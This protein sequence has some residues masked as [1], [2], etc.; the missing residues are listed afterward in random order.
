MKLIFRRGAS[1][2]MTLAL[3][4]SL[5]G[6][7]ATAAR[8]AEADD[9]GTPCGAF[10]FSQGVACKI[11]VSGGCTADCTPLN[12]E[13]G[14]TGGCAEE[15]PP[16]T[17][18]TTYCDSSC[19][20][21]CN[22]SAID[23]MAGCHGECD[24]SMTSICQQQTP[25]ADCVDQAKAQ[26][27]VH[28]QQSCSGAPSTCPGQC[29]ACCVGS[30]TGQINYQCDFDCFASLQGGCTL[31]CQQPAGAIFCNGQYVHASDVQAC[32]AYLAEQGVTVDVSARGSLECNGAGCQ[33]E[34][35]AAASA[36]AVSTLGAPGENGAAGLAL[37]GAAIA[38]VA[39]RA[40]RR[41][42]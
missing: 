26:C 22:P 18:C 33:S 8:P 35:S 37:A 19:S 17:T 12:L 20:S 15:V 25:T 2:W 23:C 27:D 13:V 16:D 14:C 9:A 42:D 21:T 31:Q 6:V 38:L 40:R 10:D 29:Q 39:A 7:V 41:R 32:I 30:C 5:A 24:Q 28:C 3:T 4:A 36:C 11:E 34:G 1:S